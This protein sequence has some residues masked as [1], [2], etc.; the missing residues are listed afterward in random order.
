MEVYHYL[1]AFLYGEFLANFFPHF[2]NHI[3]GNKYIPIF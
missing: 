3:S 1:S 2:V